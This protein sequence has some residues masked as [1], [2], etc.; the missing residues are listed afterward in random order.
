MTISGGPTVLRLCCASYLSIGAAKLRQHVQRSSVVT[1]LSA[2][3]VP[4]TAG[5]S[6]EPVQ[7]VSIQLVQLS[8]ST[9]NIWQVGL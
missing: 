6:S 8:F 1:W 3:S 5:A 9:A 7:L 2:T 4:A